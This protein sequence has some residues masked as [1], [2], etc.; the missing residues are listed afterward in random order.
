[1]LRLA[2][3]GLNSEPQ[4]PNSNTG[5]KPYA[6]ARVREGWVIDAIR[7][8]VLVHHQ[9]DEDRYQTQLDLAA[10]GVVTVESFPDVTFPVSAFL[11]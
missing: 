4:T 7:R 5:W 9:P 8:R 11:R 1:M 3:R 10:D 6:R 2:M